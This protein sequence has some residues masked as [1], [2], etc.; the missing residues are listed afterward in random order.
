MQEKNKPKVS[1]GCV[2]F[3]NLRLPRHLCRLECAF[4]APSAPVYLVSV[5]I[6]KG[7]GIIDVEVHGVVGA[8]PVGWTLVR[9]GWAGLCLTLALNAS[10]TDLVSL[11][12]GQGYQ[13]SRIFFCLLQVPLNICK[14]L[15]LTCLIIGWIKFDTHTIPPPRLLQPIANCEQ[16]LAY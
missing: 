16:I 11:F 4:W 8:G 14:R 10:S 15:N 6:H 9:R 7:L 5:V 12:R 3:R 2:S 13:R 1:S